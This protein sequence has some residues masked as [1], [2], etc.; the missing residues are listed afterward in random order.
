MEILNIFPTPVY[1]T[2]LGSFLSQEAFNHITD[3]ST[4]KLFDAVPNISSDD[5]V[6]SDDVLTPLKQEIEKHLQIFGDV[7]FGQ[8]IKFYISSSW[9]TRSENG[10]SGERHS[11]VN[12]IISGSFY[13]SDE[14]SPINFYR[15]NKS[16]LH[17]Y[18][19][20][21]SNFY[22]TLMI[23][24]YPKKNDLILFPSSLEHSISK[25]NNL[26][27]RFSVVINSYIKGKMDSKY[28]KLEIK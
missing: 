16:V 26:N 20:E 23:P 9:I 27:P 4:T 12:S 28:A 19:N 2:N 17:M 6:L 7:L 14:P 1:K 22:N 11:H 24:I 8:G 5:N 10:E 18:S 21:D 25:N 13:V 3:V 15:E